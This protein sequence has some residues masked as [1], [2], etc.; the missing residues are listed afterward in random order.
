[1]TGNENLQSTTNP[2]QFVVQQVH[3]ESIN[4]SINESGIFKVAEVVQ[5]TVRA[6]RERW[7]PVQGI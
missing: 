1:L 4:Q 6:T 7:S 3:K 2:Q 5:T